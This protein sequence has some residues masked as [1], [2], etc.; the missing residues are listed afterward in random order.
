VGR[1]FIPGPICYVQE[2]P[3]HRA[4]GKLTSAHTTLIDAA[5]PVVD[6][7]QTCSSVSKISLG[8]I[9]NI[10]KGAPG[11]KFHPVVGGWKITVRGNVS[12]QELVVYTT[13]P[14]SVRKGLLTL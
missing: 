4:G 9:K 2:M 8:L 1:L 12:L 14:E 7:L 5:V 3:L 6:F 10:G 13:E 11:M